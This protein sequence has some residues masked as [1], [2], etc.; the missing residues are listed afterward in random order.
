MSDFEK[1]RLSGAPVFLS[2]R[3]FFGFRAAE[4]LSAGLGRGEEGLMKRETFKIAQSVA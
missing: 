2:E 3:V 1:K 4:T